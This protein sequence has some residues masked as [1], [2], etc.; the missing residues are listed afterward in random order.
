MAGRGG[1]AL[2]MERL[3]AASR[4]F[5]AWYQQHY[6][7]TL[8]ITSAVFLL[9]IFHLY[10]LFTDV[11][12]ERLTGRS[13][14]AFPQSGMIVYVLADY[15]EIPALVSASLLY[16]YELRRGV[17][18]RSLFFLVLLN[19]QWIHMLW[20][21]DDVVVRTLSNTSLFSWGASVAWI[22]ILIDYLE[23]PV[24]VDTLHKIYLQRGV[25]MRRLRRRLGVE[26]PA[27]PPAPPAAP[28][29]KPPAAPRPAER[30]GHQG[31][32]VRYV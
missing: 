32:L 14:F 25:L 10:W 20:I 31:R 29:P 21:T 27:A 4:R 3:P 15:L 22:A 18:L 26:P 7:A 8:V 23:V 13:V 16:V 28:F 2:A 19:T 9:Q 1:Y 30:P 5:W 6:L 11:I 12:V 17:R 24:I